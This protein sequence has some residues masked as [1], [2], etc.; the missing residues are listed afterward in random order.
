MKRIPFRSCW[1]LA[2]FAIAG[3][4]LAPGCSQKAASSGEGSTAADSVAFAQ[5]AGIQDDAARFAALEVFLKDHPKS[6]QAAEAWPAAI[7]LSLRLA[8]EKT[9]AL[10]KKFMNT[11]I[12]SPDPYN[13]VGWDLAVQEKHLDMAVPIL[14]KAVAKARTAGDSLGLASCLDSE[15]Y[16][17]FKAGDAKAAVA[18]M[19]E[20]RNLYG[21]TI[22]EIEQHMAQIYDDAG[23]DA[24]ARPIYQEL[25]G[26][27]EHPLLR[28]KLTAIVTAAGESME[29]VNAA[30]N[31]QRLANAAPA[32]DFTLPSQAG[33]A[34]ISFAEFKGKVILLN[35]WHYT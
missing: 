3:F 20:A 24:K 21:E 17:R 26:H 15:A 30:I 11:D 31:A 19:E 33:G 32:P 16:A 27:M 6:A 13:S 23:L 14:V 12:A 35:F 10:L 5:I 18:P 34:P 4:A 22:D 9:P 29:T 8:P 25:L 7:A 2:A 28:E 1:V